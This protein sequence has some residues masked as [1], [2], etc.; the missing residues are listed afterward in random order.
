MMPTKVHKALLSGADWN[1]TVTAYSKDNNN[2][3]AGGNM[4]WYTS[5]LPSGFYDFEN[6]IYNLK[7]G[8]FSKPVKSPIGYHIIKLTETRPARGEIQV[9]HILIRK[10]DKIKNQSVTLDSIQ[11]LVNNGVEFSVLVKSF[12]QDTKTKNT[13]GV[14]PRFGINKYDPKFE[15]ACYALNTEGEISKPIETSS[16]W[17]IIKLIKKYPLNTYELEKR[18]LQ[19]LVNKDA[20]LMEAKNAMI[21]KLKQTYNFKDD[22]N[23][24][25]QFAKAQGEEFYGYKWEGV[26]GPLDDK[27]L[28]SMGDKVVNVGTFASFLKKNARARLRMNKKKPLLD[29]LMRTYEN[30]VSDQLLEYEKSYLEKKYP[31]FKAI[32]ERI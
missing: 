14:L 11:Q 24:L 27:T 3:R 7:K 5:L 13:G 25:S 23:A 21:G 19:A 30:Y 12:S 26:T 8:Q 15:D 32:N 1:Q 18:R 16:G 9:A 31:E 6:T 20:R 29:E 10:D 17:H 28:F 2:N 4:G 22:R